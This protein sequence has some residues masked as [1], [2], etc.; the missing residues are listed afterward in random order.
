MK[1]LVLECGRCG[2][3]VVARDATATRRCSCGKQNKV[4]GAVF[5]AGSAREALAWIAAAE[6]QPPSFLAEGRRVAKRRAAKH[7]GA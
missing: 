2:K 5:E 1:H 4:A 6:G 3:H 7:P